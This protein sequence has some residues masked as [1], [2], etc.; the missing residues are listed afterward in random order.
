MCTVYLK[1]CNFLL[2]ISNDLEGTWTGVLVNDTQLGDKVK[3]GDFVMS[4]SKEK[5]IGRIYFWT[6]GEEYLIRPLLD[7]THSLSKVE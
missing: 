7:G 1:R 3:I 6:T 2:S 4:F 5:L